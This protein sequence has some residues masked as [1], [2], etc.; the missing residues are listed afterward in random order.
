M[1]YL[2]V[3]YDV[4]VAH[5]RKTNET[6]CTYMQHKLKIPFN[7]AARHIYRME[8]E[9]ILSKPNRFGRR[10]VLPQCSAP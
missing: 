9:G 10:K 1:T 3:D 7:A 4:A 8:K 5:V 2:D 6:S